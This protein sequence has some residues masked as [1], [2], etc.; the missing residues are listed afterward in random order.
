M[1]DVPSFLTHKAGDYVAVAVR[2]VSRGPAEVGYLDGADS[3]TVDVNAEIPLGHKVALRDITAGEDV[4][5][6]GVRTAIASADIKKGD[7]VHVHNVRS[8][9]WQNSVA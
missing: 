8:A 7:Y 9:R 1:T 2:D 5:E 4:I 6:Y 3:V